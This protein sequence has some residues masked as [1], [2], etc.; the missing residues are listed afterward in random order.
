MT[1]EI[2]ILVVTYNAKKALARC[3][4]SVFRFTKDFS[5]RLTVVDNASIDGTSEYLRRYFSS[6]IRVIR[7]KKNLG[8]CGG[9]NLAIRRTELPWIVFLD[10]DAEVTP[11]WLKRFYGVAHKKPDTGMVG[12]R[13]VFPDGR[14]FSAEYHI[15]PFGSAGRGERDR[16]QFNYVRETDALPGPCWLMPR[17]VVRKVGGFDE[18]FFPSQYEDIDYCLR[19][20]L[21]GYKI[22][23][24]GGVR[25]V[26]SHLFRS[27]TRRV[28]RDNETKFYRKWRKIL[29]L[30]PRASHNAED[31]LMVS[32]A[33]KLYKEY[34]DPSI[35]FG[36]LPRLNRWF[37]KEFYKGVA[38]FHSGK[39]TKAV[40]FFRRVFRASRRKDFPQKEE[41]A[42]FHGILASYF[43][44]LGLHEESD[45]C[46]RWALDMMKCGG[47]KT[48][49]KK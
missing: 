25:I 7:S 30:F 24:H 49:E 20:R 44:R 48:D 41:S 22:Y 18:R 4:V 21:A 40:F 47:V 27:G 29:P 11:G 17:S 26:H 39:K 8:F 38:C 45:C 33:R 13:V 9:A 43:W 2:D 28:A 10:D 1:P 16:G 19:V 31:R 36:S 6:A 34:S 3:L 46:A 32:G 37:S 12:G 35:G 15:V 23:Y 5:Y 14:M 42:K